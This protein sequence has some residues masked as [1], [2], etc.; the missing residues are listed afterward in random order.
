M[1]IIKIR[2]DYDKLEKQINETTEKLIKKNL[3]GKLRNNF[4]S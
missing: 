2:G 1:F 4:S 3:T